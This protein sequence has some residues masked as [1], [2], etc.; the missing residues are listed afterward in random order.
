MSGRILVVRPDGGL[1]VNSVAG[2]RVVR[3]LVRL[4]RLFILIRDVLE[5]LTNPF[6][7]PLHCDHSPFSGL[8][9]SRATS[10]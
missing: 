3:L 2:I 5:T 4:F 10:W 9:T 6:G 7:T 1:G 8:P